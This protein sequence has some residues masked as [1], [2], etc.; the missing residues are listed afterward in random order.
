MTENELATIVVDLAFKI[1][2]RLGPGLLESAYEAILVRELTK[3]GFAVEVQKPISVVW[4]GEELALGFR[5]DVIVENVGVW[6]IGFR[7]GASAPPG[8]TLTQLP[9]GI[10]SPRTH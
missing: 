4:E 1:H 10:R 5:A 9:H 3:Q 7:A 2:S 6:G 8:V